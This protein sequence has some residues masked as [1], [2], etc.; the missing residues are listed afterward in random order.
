MSTLSPV[1]QI[2]EKLSIEQLIGETVQLKRAGANYTGL[3][4]FH[5]EKTPSFVVSPSRGSYHCFGCGAGGDI[6]SF[7][8]ASQHVEFGEALRRLAQRTGVVLES[9][10]ESKGRKVQQTRLFDVT[11]AAALFFQQALS[12]PAGAGA[13]A[14]LDRRGI[15]P[16]TRARFGIGYAPDAWEALYKRLRAAG[17]PDAEIEAAGL[18]VRHEERGTLHDRFRGRVMLPIRDVQGRVLGFGGRVLDAGEPKYL[19][20]PHTPLFDKSRVLF[21][22]DLARDTIRRSGEAVL[23]EGYLDAVRAHQA[24]FANV[25]ATLGTAITADQLGQAARLAPRLVLAL[26]ADPAGQKAAARAGLLALSTLRGRTNGAVDLR[27]AALPAGLDPDELIGQS[28]DGWR[29]IIAAAVPIVDHYFGLAAAE[30]DPQGSDYK[31]RLI[32]S[33]LPVIRELPGVGTQQTYLER[34][35]RLTGVEVPLLRK[36]LLA[37]QP[38]GPPAA[39]PAGTPGAGEGRARRPSQRAQL[40]VLQRAA[41]ARDRLQVVEESLL[42]LLLVHLPLEE[43]LVGD[44]SEVALSTPQRQALLGRLL[45][46]DEEALAAQQGRVAP[47]RAGVDLVAALSLIGADDETS[48]EM[49]ALVERVAALAAAAPHV[50]RERLAASAHVYLSTLRDLRLRTELRVQAD[51]LAGLA[52][53]PGDAPLQ[54]AVEGLAT[55]HSADLHMLEQHASY[56]LHS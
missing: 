31:Q 9:T 34:L 36:T 28:P 51:M 17:H 2:K 8:M 11:A 33:L 40:A 43:S 46:L 19:N 47:A 15:A 38:A 22:L 29:E 4:P 42:A 25:V 18:A 49:A 10:G 3:C 24:G 37:A 20:S 23:V 53:Q 26:D 27:V 35:G 6:L 13:R 14:Y 1:E 5:N 12:G 52:V 55:R 56:R 21:G 16:E 54:R 7:V 32:D 50:P 45:V 48:P 41:A 39:G 44:L 30:L